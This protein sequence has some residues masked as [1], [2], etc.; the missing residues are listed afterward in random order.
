MWLGHKSSTYA[1]SDFSVKWW[2]P[3][4]PPLLRH[5]TIIHRVYSAVSCEQASGT[6]KKK[7]NNNHICVEKTL[8]KK[9][10]E[11]ADESFSKNIY[12]CVPLVMVL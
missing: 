8:S 9:A 5:L 10:D 12:L 2:R 7:K 11:G 3:P 1:D 6:K 4:H